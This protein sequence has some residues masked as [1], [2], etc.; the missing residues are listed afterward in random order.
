VRL[1]R[2]L[3]RTEKSPDPKMLRDSLEQQFGLP[4]AL[5][6]RADRAR[7][8]GHLSGEKDQCLVGLGIYEA[9]TPQLVR[10][11]VLG[12]ATIEQNALVAND[13]AR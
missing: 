11:M 9:N 1:D 6:E 5:V 8:Q 13:S 3:R 12:A 7:G 2:I 10:I 4:A